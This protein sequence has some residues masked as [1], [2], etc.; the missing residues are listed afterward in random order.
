MGKTGSLSRPRRFE[1]AEE[2]VEWALSRVGKR[3]VLGTPLALGKPPHLLNA[4]YRRAAEDPSLEL[5][6]FT[7]L[8][9][10]APKGKSELER[11]LVGPLAERLFGGYPEIAYAE[12]LRR[13]TLPDNV[14]VHEFYF[15]PGSMMGSPA[16]QQSYMSSNYTHVVRDVLDAGINVLAQLVAVEPPGD[17]SGGAAGPGE[18]RLSLSCNSDLTVDLLPHFRARE[19]RGEPIA[20]LAQ[21][22]RE[23]PFMLGPAD[24][25]ASAFH[26]VVDHPDLEFPLFGPPDGPIALA[27]YGIAAHVSALVRD[28]GTLQLGIGSLGDAIVRLLQ[29]RHGESATYHEILERLRIPERYG[30]LVGAWGGTAPFE[31]GL[32]GA[33]EMLVDGFL[34]LYDSGILKRR[35]YPDLALQR[36]ADAGEELSAAE[37]ASGRLA[38]ACFFLGPRELY[39]RLREM[40]RA[41]RELFEMTGISHVNELYDSPGTPEALK[42]AQRRDAR[43]VNSCLMMTLLGAAVSDGLEDGRVISGVGGQYNFVAMAQALDDG[44]SILMLRST[45]TAGGETTSNLVFSYGHAT[46]PRHLRDIVVT[47]YGIADVRGKSDAEVIAALLEI[48]DSRF[49]DELLAEAQKAGKIASGYQIPDRCQENTPERLAADLA[50]FRGPAG[51]RTGR[52]GVLPELPYGT[53][54]TAEE[55]V[56]VK[57]LGSLK[58][59]VE[60]RD[61]SLLPNWGELKK[62]LDVPAAARPYLE[63]MAL[64]RPD[65]LKETLLQRAV[66]LALADVG[67]I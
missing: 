59:K 35:A 53:E 14:R 30:A 32:Y 36:R 2:C 31:Q 12:P 45:R 39:R 17:G 10:T 49:Q 47:E 46:I 43:F 37:R 67:A 34:E 61:L 29:V 56:L 16:A 51:D 52:E 50:P 19:R 27:D 38:H 5:S 33:T 26:A 24:V 54:L 65:G 62:T 7:A 40:P 21:V 57:A 1:D 58:E 11:R 42:R 25:P 41:E 18:E 13:G 4:F 55:I 3:V 22:N 23:L 9:L 48:A 44:R 28:G 8:T 66:V 15:Q 63:R 20:L 6:I 60:A 64:D